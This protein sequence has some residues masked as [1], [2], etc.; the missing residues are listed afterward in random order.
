MTVKTGLP[1][2][3]V[4]TVCLNCASEITQTIN[5]VAAQHYPHV[6]YIVVDG[7]S[8]DG[9]LEILRGR[10]GDISKF[11]S[12]KDTGLYDAMNKGKRLATGDFVFFLNA[13]DV[14]V[15][16]DTLS[17]LAERMHDYAAVYF[18]RVE[19]RSS[20]GSWLTP[21]GDDP[22]RSRSRYLPHHQSIFY[23]R[24][25]FA[26]NDYDLS[27]R[28]QA[29]LDFTTKAMLSTNANFVGLTIA[30]S[31][32]GGYTLLTFS[33]WRRT[34]RISEEFV[35]IAREN[36]RRMAPTAVFSLYLKQICKFLAYRLSG[37]KMLFRLMK[38]A[39][40]QR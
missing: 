23:P 36:G 6:E 3:S 29:D 40:L 28:V 27:Y 11:V 14:F 38:R 12:E 2:I 32:L 34:L 10:A 4:V 8:T 20:I 22:M 31:H 1:T 25:F 15:D 7:C 24:A 18:G 30:I 35:R 26:S 21:I 13:G 5:S 33:S 16:A 39:A 19:I 9:T 17:S 37:E